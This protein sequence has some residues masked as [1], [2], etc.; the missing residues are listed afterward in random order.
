MGFAT[1]VYPVP[2]RFINLAKEPVPG[3]VVAATYTLPCTTFKPADKY[4]RLEDMAWR[5]AMAKLYNLVDGVRI[6]DVSVGGPLFADGI[7]YVLADILG[8]YWQAVVG[9]TQ[10]VT[11]SLSGSVSVGATSIVVGSTAVAVNAIVSIGALGT[12]A[13]EVRKVTNVQAGTLT[14]NAAIYQGHASGGTVISY[15]GY[16]G[17]QHNFSTLNTGGG[18]LGMGGWSQSQPPTYTYTDFSGVPAG[19]GA[20]NYSFAC[21]SEVTISGDAQGLVEWDGKM[22]A[23]ASQIAA[24]RPTTQL[25]SV[26][27]QASWVSTVAIGGSGTNNSASWKLTLTR[28]VEPKFTNQGTQDPFSIVR[29]YLEAGLGFDF[30]PA[31]DETE[32]IYYLQNTQNACQIVAGNNLAGAAATSFTINAQTLGYTDSALEDGK[33][34]FGFSESAKCIANVTNIGPSGGFSP[35]SISLVNQ[36]ISY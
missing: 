33:D 18:G 8:D 2:N 3:S 35:L 28:K 31:S 34:T 14:L 36:V 23:L 29:G 5:N 32:F 7:G 19:T 12:T 11:T 15:S 26:I 24:T 1:A 6:S 20:R 25:T 13:E 22:T 30:D 10:A 16:N 27:P 9:G 17:I 4:T 21:F